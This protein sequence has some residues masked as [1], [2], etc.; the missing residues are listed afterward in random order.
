M[1]E[2]EEPLQVLGI[3]GSLRRASYNRALLRAA[4]ELAD[5]SITMRFHDLRD[6]PLYDADVESRGDPDAVR[7][8]KEAIA[9]ADA[10]LIAT[11]EYQHSIPGVLKNALDWASRPRRESVLNGKPAAILGATPGRGAT[12]RA[13]SDLRKVLAYSRMHVYGGSS[14]LIPNAAEVFDDEGRLSD[15]DTRRKVR[16]AVHGLAAWTRWLVRCPPPASS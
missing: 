4:K 1:N 2:L 14:V 9:D 10:L 11:P 16:E 15:E 13:Q 3:A 6:V 12:A 5:D 7:A 8:L